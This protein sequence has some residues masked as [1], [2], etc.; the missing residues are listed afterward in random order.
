[1]KSKGFSTI[2]SPPRPVNSSHHRMV[3][4][5]ARS[6]GH[7]HLSTRRSEQQ[8]VTGFADLC[9][10]FHVPDVIALDVNLAF[11]CQQMKRGNRR[12]H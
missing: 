7:V 10:F 12:S 9:E 11:G 1:M 4:F 6:V 5:S 3:F 2:P 8:S